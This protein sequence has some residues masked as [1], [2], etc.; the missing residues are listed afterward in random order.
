MKHNNSINILREFNPLVSIC[1]PAFNS[2]AY[3]EQTFTSI[4]NQTYKNLEI[5][6]IDDGS[7]DATSS[8]LKSITDKRLQYIYQE[9]KGASAARNKAFQISTGSFIK[10][11]DADDILSENFV[12]EQVLAIE[13]ESDCIA[14][15]KWGIFRKPDMSDF[16]FVKE[17]VWKDMS[18]IDWV[19]ESLIDYGR[20]MTQPGIFLIPRKLI[21]QEGLWDESLSLIDDFEFMMRILTASKKVKFCQNAILYYR[22]GMAESLSRQISVKHLDSAFRSQLLGVETLLSRRNNDASRLAA[23]NS[24]QLWAYGFYPNNIKYYLLFQKKIQELGGSS[25]KIEGGKIYKSI[26]KILGWKMAKRFKSFL[27]R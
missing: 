8:I 5:I 11:M 24:L 7:T 21:E 6:I 23:A 27:K 4:N 9:N 25:L 12:E 19:I 26:S 20:N 14:S 17:K 1:I 22:S 16:V 10:F 13:N 2:A 3:I 15:S 18:G